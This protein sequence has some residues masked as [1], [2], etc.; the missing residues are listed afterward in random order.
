MKILFVCTGNS[1][2]SPMAEGL[3]EK[4]LKYRGIKDI[5]VFSA[6]TSPVLDAPPSK[7]TIEILRE[8]GIDISTHRGAYVTHDL[9][10]GADLILVMGK[11]HKEEIL[12]MRPDVKDKVF[13][14]KEFAGDGELD[15]ID[16][17]GQPREIYEKCASEIKGALEKSLPKIIKMAK[18]QR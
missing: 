14:L 11:G 9:I 1:C 15:V 4:M 5:E 7:E 8:D 10:S 16:P 3:L 17:I 18:G 6:G 12:A 13:L 2:R